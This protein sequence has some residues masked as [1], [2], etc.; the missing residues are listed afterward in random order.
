MSGEE[1]IP[2]SGAWR[3]GD[4]AGRR[5]FVTLCDD[6]PLALRVGATLSPVTVAYETWGMLAPARD[7]AVL[8]LPRAHRRQLT[9]PV[10]PKPAIRCS[11]GGTR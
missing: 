8:G 7:N 4:D 5:Q 6:K 1:P 10:R 2:V 11:D 9:P 3:P